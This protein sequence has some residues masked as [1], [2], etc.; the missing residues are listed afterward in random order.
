MS[1]AKL[2]AQAEAHLS[3]T[4]PRMARFIDSFGPCALRRGNSVAKSA[5]AGLAQAITHQQLA[6]AAARTI[7]GRLVTHLGTVTPQAVMATDES[8]LRACG[9]SGSKAAS[10]RHLAQ[11]FLDGTVEPAKLVRMSNDDVVKCLTVVRGIG[12]WS[13]QMFLIFDMGRMDVWPTSDYG[14]R[15]GFAKGWEMGEL[16]TPKELDL[17]GEKYR[18]YRS[19]VAWYCWRVWDAANAKA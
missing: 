16:P 3:A 11:C 10:L 7:H 1:T 14:V 17:A 13:A 6:G 19:V 5:F 4:D 12:P 2:V 8:A 18:P 9:L 15:A